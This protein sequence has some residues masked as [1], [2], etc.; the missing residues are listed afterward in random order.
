MDSVNQWEPALRPAPNSPSAIWFAAGHRYL[1]TE[2][3]KRQTPVNTV[4]PTPPLKSPNWTAAPGA[5]YHRPMAK[6]KKPQLSKRQQ[7]KIR[8]QQVIF[9]FIAVILIASMVVTLFT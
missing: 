2:R 1:R 9:G 7:R 6:K 3:R 8:T 5:W 4:P